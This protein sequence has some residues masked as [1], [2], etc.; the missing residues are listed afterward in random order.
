MLVWV[1]LLREHFFEV[2]SELL[3]R[4]RMIQAICNG[5]LKIAKFATTIVA[6]TVK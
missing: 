1:L 4:V 2:L 3:P 5:C 6:D